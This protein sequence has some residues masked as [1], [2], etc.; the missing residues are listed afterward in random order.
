MS[1]VRVIVIVVLSSLSLKMLIALPD[2]A[3]LYQWQTLAGLALVAFSIVILYRQYLAK[4]LQ[5][6]E[7]LIHEATHM[8]FAALMFKPVIELVAS[9]QTGH[10]VYREQTNWLISLSPYFFPLPTMALLALSFIAK[11]GFQDALNVGI[12]LTYILF[13][14]SLQAQLRPDQ[15][16]IEKTG[17]VFSYTVIY[18]FHF[19]LLIVLLLCLQDSL[20][21]LPELLFG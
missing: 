21:V 18:Q 15:D 3:R 11:D 1:I 8:L 9:E 6:W 14:S 19:Q 10:V 12:V 7:T 5:F 17:K 16:D 13:L 20:G 4:H 2:I